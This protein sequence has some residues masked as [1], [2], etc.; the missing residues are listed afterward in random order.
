MNEIITDAIR[1]QKGLQF[2]YH[3]T[4]RVVEPHTF[5]KSKKNND[6]LSAY[7]VGGES[8]T[9]D[10]GWKLFLISDIS[11]LS[12]GD[13]FNHIADGYN[14]NDDKNMNEIY[15]TLVDLDSL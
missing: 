9:L 4:L 14:M 6:V 12:A 7:Q 8:D 15:I 11:N 2:S 13:E 5:G 3:G 1:N 10:T